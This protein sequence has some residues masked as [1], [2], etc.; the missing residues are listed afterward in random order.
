MST[1]KDN[2]ALLYVLAPLALVLSAALVAQAWR[3]SR[4]TAILRTPVRTF[5]AATP[6][7]GLNLAD[8][9]QVIRDGAL[10]YATR[11][12]YTPVLATPATTMAELSRYRLMGTLLVPRKPAVAFLRRG[13]GDNATAVSPGDHL[14]GWTVKAVQSGSAVFGYGGQQVTLTTT[15]PLGTAA[16]QGLTIVP[17]GRTQPRQRQ[18]SPAHVARGTPRR[19]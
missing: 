18:A 14:D 12:F 10:F 1:P 2:S 6:P 13:Q 16:P 15:P 19:T 11:K 17:L 9:L 4:A 8:D 3:G 5:A 7:D